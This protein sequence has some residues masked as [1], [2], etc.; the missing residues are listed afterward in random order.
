MHYFASAPIA[1]QPVS[2]H[3]FPVVMSVYDLS[4]TLA[5]QLCT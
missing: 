2:T 5:I 4:N 1:L 3:P